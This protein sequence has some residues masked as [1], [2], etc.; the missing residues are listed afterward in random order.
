[1]GICV[2]SPPTE[3]QPGP[4]RAG[5]AP[6]RSGPPPNT[7]SAAQTGAADD[8]AE[9]QRRRAERAAAAESRAKAALNRGKSTNGASQGNGK[10]STNLYGDLG[11]PVSPGGG[12]KREKSQWEIE[13]QE[14]L[15]A[16]IIHTSEKA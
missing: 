14:A 5:H 10:S 2:S 13:N 8:P 15:G 9:A 1:M 4:Q 3:A 12:V 7:G 16:A 6:G 11:G